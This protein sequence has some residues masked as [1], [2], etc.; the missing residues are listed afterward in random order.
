[1]S[2]RFGGVASAASIVLLLLWANGVAALVPGLPSSRTA[3]A[4]LFG[5]AVAALVAAFAAGRGRRP[6]R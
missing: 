6:G 4:L 3:N 5:F 1:M 2:R